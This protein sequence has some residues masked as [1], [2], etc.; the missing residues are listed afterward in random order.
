MREVTAKEAKNRF[1]R[2]LESAQRAPVRVTRNGR[3]VGVMMS[4]QQ[5]ERLRG[6]AWERLADTMDTLGR[7]ASTRGLTDSELESLLADES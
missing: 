2:L 5:F 3:P 1:G 4:M 6:V 7:E